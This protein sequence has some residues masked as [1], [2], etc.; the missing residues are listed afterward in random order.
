MT[1]PWVL[2][3]VEQGRARAKTPALTTRPS[4]NQPPSPGLST[5]VSPKIEPLPEKA[6]VPLSDSS[7]RWVQLFLSSLFQT[8]RSLDRT[9]PQPLPGSSPGPGG[10]A[11]RASPPK[12]DTGWRSSLNPARLPIL[13]PPWIARS[14]PGWAHPQPLPPYSEAPAPVLGGWTLSTG[15]GEVAVHPQ[16]T[17]PPRLGLPGQAWGRLPWPWDQ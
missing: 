12:E 9:L 17:C 7:P 4:L 1:L 10:E 13:P 16:P 14:L 2:D 3:R 15:Q 5:G 6:E 11:Q 8:A